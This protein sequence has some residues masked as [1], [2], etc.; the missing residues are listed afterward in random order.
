VGLKVERYERIV[1]YATVVVLVLAFA[2]IV[3]SVVE[4][5]I[6]LPED[7][8]TID[9]SAV[10]DTP[11][12]DAPGLYQVGENEYEAVVVAQAF[13]FNPS[14]I[15][16]PAGSSVTFL[17]TSV[18]VTHGFMIPRT[19]VNGMVLPGQIT[20]LTADFDEPGEHTIVCHEFCGIGHHAMFGK[21]VVEE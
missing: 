7:Y 17:I 6:H 11:P 13:S 9:P 16:I 10:S 12:F 14:E 15:R 1:L 21:V 20:R 3:V 2:A 5:N 8:A 19:A 4:S 18:D